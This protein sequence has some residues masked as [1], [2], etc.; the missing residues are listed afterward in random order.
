MPE[1]EDAPALLALHRRLLD[2]DRVASEELIA[3]LLSPLTDR[4]ARRFPHTDEQLIADGIVDALLEYCA[5]PD[6][7]DAERGVPLD[8][9]LSTAAW[10]NIA[11]SLRGEHRRKA[12][13]EKAHAAYG[14][15]LVALDPTA[16]NLL[17]QEESAQR[18]RRE[19]EVMQMVRTPADQEIVTLR[20]QGERRTEVFADIL[21]I[22]HLPAAEQRR[23][24]K[25]AKDRIDKVLRR[26]QGGDV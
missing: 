10:R 2:G 20:L 21:G 23:A 5:Q 4:L 7:F 12:R 14:E 15:P 22:A 18:R 3:L 6:R 19:V 11:N 1:D 17:Q 9:F 8:R 16:G 26:H 25:R 13:E 24:V